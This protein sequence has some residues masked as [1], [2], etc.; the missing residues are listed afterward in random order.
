MQ[1]KI[2]IPRLSAVAKTLCSIVLPLL[3]APIALAAPS[4]TGPSIAG[5][6]HA[7]TIDPSDGTLYA[8]GDVN[9][10]F[11]STKGGSSWEM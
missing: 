7:T 9:G 3:L 6:I 10:V 1:Q 5:Q 11:G 2:S 4:A 8:G